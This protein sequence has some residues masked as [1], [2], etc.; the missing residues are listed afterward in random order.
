MV[1]VPFSNHRHVVA[2]AR[3]LP[4]WILLSACGGQ[5]EQ[6]TAGRV[7]DRCDSQWPVCDR[8]AGC[9]LG[10]QSFIEGKLPGQNQLAIQLFEPSTVKVSLYLDEVK[11]AGDE[12]VISFFEDRCRARIR[13]AIPGRTFVGEAQTHGFVTREADLTGIGDHL[14]EL[15]SDAKASYLLKVEV[16]PK[17]VP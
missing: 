2:H 6:F 11:A 16:L 9:L 17:R 14:I 10:D 5:R 12:T 7:L 13:E 1:L 8:I 4:M 15:S 3:W